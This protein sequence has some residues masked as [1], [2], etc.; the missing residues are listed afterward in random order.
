MQGLVIQLLVM[1]GLIMHVLVMQ[2]LIYADISY[3]EFRDYN[4]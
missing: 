2:G 3:A 1:Q 4:T